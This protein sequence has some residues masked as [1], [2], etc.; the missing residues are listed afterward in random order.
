MITDGAEF[1]LTAQSIRPWIRS[2]VA[3]GRGNSLV[4]GG[5]GGRQSCPREAAGKWGMLG[6]GRGVWGEARCLQTSQQ[7]GTAY[8]G[9]AP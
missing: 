8:G 6:G 3:P 4:W 5:G 2:T 9:E 7:V 1:P